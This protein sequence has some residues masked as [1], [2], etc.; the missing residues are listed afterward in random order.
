MTEIITSFAMGDSVPEWLIA[1]EP[2]SPGSKRGN[3][4]FAADVDVVE[5]PDVFLV[6]IRSL[7]S[8]YTVLDMGGVQGCRLFA[9][10][11]PVRIINATIDFLPEGMTPMVPIN[12]QAGRDFLDAV[13]PPSVAEAPRSS[14]FR[15]LLA[16]LFGPFA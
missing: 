15:R 6:A 9:A 4:R 5:T 13:Q 10:S 1:V 14:Y 12:Q 2:M 11:K 8:G 3:F 16:A 7:A